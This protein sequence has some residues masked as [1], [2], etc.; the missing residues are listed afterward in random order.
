MTRVRKVALLGYPAVGKS[1]LAYQFVQHRF[2]EDY[3]TTIENHLTRNFN[4]YGREFELHLFDTMGVTELP[5]FPEDYLLKDGWIIVFSVTS[6]RSFDVVK[7]IYDKLETSRP[8]PASVLPIVLVGNKA[9]LSEDR[10]VSVDEGKSLAQSINAVYMETSAKNNTNVS[11]VFKNI[12]IQIEKIQGDP[13]KPD[14][15]DCAIL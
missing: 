3:C 15:N 7:E 8:G 12:L 4:V 9:D 5:S 2:E 13:I 10:E 6:R 1:S 14:K 11:D